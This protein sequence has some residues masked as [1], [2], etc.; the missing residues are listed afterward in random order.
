LKKASPTVML[1]GASDGLKCAVCW[2][3]AMIP[4]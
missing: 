1:H 3:F 4:A 2:S